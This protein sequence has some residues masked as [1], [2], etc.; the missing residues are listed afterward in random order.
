MSEYDGRHKVAPKSLLDT[1]RFLQCQSCG[2]LVEA[3]QG[4]D[5]TD[6]ERRASY[7]IICPGRAARAFRRSEPFGYSGR[8]PTNRVRP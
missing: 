4:H 3:T 1:S 7:E 8:I 2:I 6:E 5:F